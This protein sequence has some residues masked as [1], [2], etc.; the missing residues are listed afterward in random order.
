[1]FQSIVVGWRAHNYPLLLFEQKLHIPAFI[2]ITS[3][4]R[5]AKSA[6]TTTARPNKLFRKFNKTNIVNNKSD[7]TQKEYL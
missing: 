4:G 7:T 3:L 6:I 5:S 1:M 2:V